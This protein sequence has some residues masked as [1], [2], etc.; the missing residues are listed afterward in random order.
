MANGQEKPA[1]PSASAQSDADQASR[2]GKDSTEELKVQKKTPSA[3]AGSKVQLLSLKTDRSFQTD[4]D[5]PDG[6]RADNLEYR[7]PLR[8]QQTVPLMAAYLPPMPYGDPYGQ[9]GHQY[10][11]WPLMEEEKVPEEDALWDDDQLDPRPDA[12]EAEDDNENGLDLL[13]S[14]RG[15]KVETGPPINENVAKMANDLWAKG[16]DPKIIKTLCEQ[17]PTPENTLQVG[18]LDLNEV[19][20]AIPKHV[21]ARDL[22]IQDIQGVMAR[23]AVP[24]V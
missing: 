12:P 13:E 16:R 19:I 21:R 11:P 10:S 22:K 24:A 17:Y 7:S 15:D 18:K 8:D 9:Y 20:S 3:A 23:A 6:S 2:T 5:V 4:Q 1:K 14:F